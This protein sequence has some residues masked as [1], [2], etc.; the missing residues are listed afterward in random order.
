MFVSEFDLVCGCEDGLIAVLDVRM[1]DQALHLYH[2]SSAVTSLSVFNTQTCMA[3][4]C[5]KFSVL[6]SFVKVYR[7]IEAGTI[8]I[9]F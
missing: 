3:G 2:S 4:Y 9:T 7:K 8:F 1:T 6:S 5:K